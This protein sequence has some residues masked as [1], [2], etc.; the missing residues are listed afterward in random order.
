MVFAKA[1]ILV[2]HNV[3]QFFVKI[4]AA[5]PVWKPALRASLVRTVLFYGKQFEA[6]GDIPIIHNFACD[7]RFANGVAHSIVRMSV[8]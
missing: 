5:K 4:S 6:G 7:F 1:A 2:R 8:A 3:K